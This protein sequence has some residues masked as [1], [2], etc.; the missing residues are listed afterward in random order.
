MLKKA[1]DCKEELLARFAQGEPTA[2]AEIVREHQA[3]VFSLA[4]HFLKDSALAE[5]LA[6]E[7][8]LQLYQNRAAIKSADHLRFWLRKVT[9]HRSMDCARRSGPRR[10]ISLEDVPEPVAA[11]MAS[12]PLLNRRLWKLV[13][14]LPE[15]SR[16]VLILRYQEDLAYQEIAEV[17]EMPVN[18]VKSTLERALALLRG[19]LERAFGGVR[20]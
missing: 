10:T 1:E 20:A 17:M 19:K 12:D 14:S 11:D 4:A 2:F 13:G 6:Q 9:C 16:M 15:R 18:T 8:F 3:M 5:D 7:V